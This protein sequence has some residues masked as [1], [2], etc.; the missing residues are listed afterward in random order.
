MHIG[1]PRTSRG[2]GVG[3]GGTG[4]VTSRP[5]PGQAPAARLGSAVRGTMREAIAGSGAL[6]GQFEWGVTG[7]MD[8]QATPGSK[9][10]EC[11]AV[12]APPSFQ[13]HGPSRGQAEPAHGEGRGAAIHDPTSRANARRGW[14]GHRVKRQ[15][16]GSACFRAL[17]PWAGHHGLGHLAISGSGRSPQ[18][19]RHRYVL[20]S[21]RY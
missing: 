19:V 3:S 16:P 15:V 6:V 20:L 14:P 4:T 8:G 13:A 1:D 7:R 12:D 11:G 17:D 2:Y 5:A 21:L 10:I 18:T 9:L